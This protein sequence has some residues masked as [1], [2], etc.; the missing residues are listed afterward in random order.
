MLIPSVQLCSLGTARGHGLEI[1]QTLLSQLENEVNRA[2]KVICKL[3]HKTGLESVIGF[4]SNARIKMGKLIGDL[5]LLEENKNFQFVRSLIENFSSKIGLSPAFCGS[6][7]TLPDGRV[8]A[9]CKPGG[10]NSIDLVES[11]ANPS[12][13]GL[14]EATVNGA[15]F[16]FEVRP[17]TITNKPSAAEVHELARRVRNL[18]VRF[19]RADR[20]RQPDEPSLAH[21]LTIT[22]ASG[23]LEGGVGILAVD[24]LL[25]KL[26]GEGWVNPLRK[27]VLKRVAGGAVLGGVLTGAGGLAISEFLAEKRR[28]ERN[29]L[30]ARVQKTDANVPPPGSDIG[31][32][33]T[34]RPQ[35]LFDSDSDK[36]RNKLLTG[37]GIAAVAGGGWTFPAARRLIGIQARNIGVENL[38]LKE[39]RRK[40]RRQDRG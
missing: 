22:T 21:D 17:G 38:G 26:A 29:N 34:K 27:G 9:R 12:Q 35:N 8:A 33:E 2:G 30:I 23:A 13:T 16:E 39:G 7:D 25:K 37:A 11:P 5:Q 1:D 15:R 24:P 28:R 31:P 20:E 3:N 18:Q 4:V 36:R 32:F 14:F 10:L 6:S 40:H 19:D